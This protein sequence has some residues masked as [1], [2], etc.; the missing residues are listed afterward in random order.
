VG[1][2]ERLGGGGWRGA[3][4][5]GGP[6][7]DP[8]V[9]AADSVVLTFAE[10]RARGGDAG[11][12]HFEVHPVRRRGLAQSS[13]DWPR[14]KQPRSSRIFAGL[15]RGS[16]ASAGSALALAKQQQRG[17]RPEAGHA[18]HAI[19]LCEQVRVLPCESQ[20]IHLAGW[21]TLFERRALLREIIHDERRR[22]PR[23]VRGTSAVLDR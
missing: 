23:Q 1:T 13:T 22:S 10:G 8:L 15:G 16:A 2:D 7:R 17:T 14:Q 3:P 4:G 20:R 11:P 18:V 5:G 19:E 21:A 9:R 12:L 6:E